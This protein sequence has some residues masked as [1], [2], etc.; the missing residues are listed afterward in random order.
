M[1]TI[2]IA[3]GLHEIKC[4]KIM[5]ELNALSM[6][7]VCLIYLFICVRVHF[8]LKRPTSQPTGG[9]CPQFEKR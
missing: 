1:E 7:C 8:F 3:T 6:M 9:R 5:I 4:I 2:E